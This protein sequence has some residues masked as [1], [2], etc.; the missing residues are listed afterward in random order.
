MCP[1]ISQIVRCDYRLAALQNRRPRHVGRFQRCWIMLKGSTPNYPKHHGATVET[2]F[3]DLI[4]ARLNPPADWQFPLVRKISPP[5][6]TTTTTPP[7]PPPT[8]G[9]TPPGRF[10][11]SRIWMCGCM[12]LWH[13]LFHFVDVW[14]CCWQTSVAHASH[15]ALEHNSVWGGRQVRLQK[16]QPWSDFPTTLQRAA[17]ITSQWNIRFHSFRWIPKRLPP[18]VF[19]ATYSNLQLYAEL[20]EFHWLFNCLF[21]HKRKWELRVKNYW[22]T[23][24]DAVKQSLTPPV[25][26]EKKKVV[27]MCLRPST[28]L[29]YSW[30]TG[31]K[32]TLGDIMK[33]HL[34]HQLMQH[35]SIFVQTG[36]A[37][38]ITMM[39]MQSREGTTNEPKCDYY[40]PR[41]LKTKQ[42]LLQNPSGL[43]RRGQEFPMSPLSNTIG[44]SSNI[45]IGGRLFIMII[46]SWWLRCR[47]LT[48]VDEVIKIE[49][50]RTDGG[51]LLTFW[52]HPRNIAKEIQTTTKE[53]LPQPPETL[54]VCLTEKRLFFY[55]GGLRTHAAPTHPTT[56]RL[57]PHLQDYSLIG[58]EG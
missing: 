25:I 41:H 29:I 17:V 31:I 40:P 14:L 44:F 35:K 53:K 12:S 7:T 52:P 50:K 1:F 28:S 54:S 30:V 13:L 22:V 49:K 39:T 18:T 57:L 51:G 15:A 16:C 56:T 37:T 48:D 9:P 46:I 10:Q 2:A 8:H 23:F 6:P 34:S 58:C 42:T 11:D 36:R 47:I 5:P 19:Y 55:R 21:Q 38:Y 43:Q 26:A 20:L 32:I 33:F 27:L 45:W 24:L 4:N 3:G